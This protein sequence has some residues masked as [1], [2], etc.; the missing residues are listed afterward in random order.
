MGRM[1]EAHMPRI[2]PAISFEDH[3]PSESHENHDRSGNRHSGRAASF[4]PATDKGY[5][6]A[7]GVKHSACSPGTTPRH[8]TRPTCS[9]CWGQSEPL[10]FR[11]A[12]RL[13]GLWARRRI[14]H[15]RDRGG[16]GSLHSQGG[17][18]GRPSAWISP[19]IV[20]R[21]ALTTRSMPRDVGNPARI[22]SWDAWL[23]RGQ[24]FHNR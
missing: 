16:Q 1:A 14:D 22:G 10:V 18:S 12:N 6:A 5:M 23:R 13:T 19:T 7:T 9:G 8:P 4:R 3:A 15:R 24:G 17:G 2:T 21:P 11:V 20:W